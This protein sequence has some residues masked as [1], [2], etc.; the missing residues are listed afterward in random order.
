MKIAVFS[1]IHGNIGA[2]EAVMN[3]I[4]TENVDKLICLGDLVGYGPYPNEVI[5]LIKS[6]NIPTVM[7]NYDDGVGF[8]RDDCGCAYTTPEE[9]R[10]GDI[11]LEWT[12][13]AVT[14]EN[15][16]FLRSLLPRIELDVLG[17]KLLFV[18]GSPRR[19]NEYLF[20]DRSI[21]SLR[22][23]FKSVDTD[24]LIC[25]HTH[26]PY[27]RYIDNKMVINDGSVGKP[28]KYHGG[29]SRYST[30]AC[31]ALIEINDNETGV[32]FRRIPYD[33]EKMAKDTEKA[34]LPKH[35]ANIL[36]GIE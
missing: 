32:Q 10:L 35:F 17:K 26:I 24:I 1:D 30:D 2:L 20:F 5:E 3:D 19:I 28:K 16:E 31:Y 6:Q 15:K 34:G 8:D 33:Y 4:K 13:N 14:S 25:G 23:I 29:Q 36:R 11:S 9:R 21:K 18:H 27:V 12:K 22:N 7:G